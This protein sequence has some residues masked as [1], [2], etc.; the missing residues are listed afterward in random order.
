MELNA[1]NVASNDTVQ[2]GNKENLEEK[3]ASNEDVIAKA[4][5]D[6]WTAGQQKQLE[7]ALRTFPSSDPARWD[8]IVEAVEGK[9]KKVI[10]ASEKNS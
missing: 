8:K 1:S 3:P 10:L 5:A 2:N 9:N 4:D 7:T 6:D